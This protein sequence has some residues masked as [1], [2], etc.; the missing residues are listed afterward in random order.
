MFTPPS[1]P[2]LFPP[3]FRRG[4]VTES[5]GQNY[6]KFTSELREFINTSTA[7]LLYPEEWDNHVADVQ[8]K[9]LKPSAAYGV[10]LL[11]RLMV[12]LPELLPPSTPD[13]VRTTLYLAAEEL[14]VF[15]TLNWTHLT[16][17]QEM[18]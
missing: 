3:L 10:D 2:I 16:Q 5:E 1:P 15:I 17:K 18:T 11:V 7:E 12:K 9:D 13:S 14:L 8:S 6:S 4:Y